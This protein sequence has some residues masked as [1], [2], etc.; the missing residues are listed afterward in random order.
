ML[1][2]SGV[3]S[4]CG[5]KG[6]YL[7]VSLSATVSSGKATSLNVALPTGGVLSGVA[8]G[9]RHQG[10]GGICVQSSSPEGNQVRTA[11][12]GA[13]SMTQLF[14]GSYDV[15]FVGGCGNQVSVAPQAYR[16]DP[17]FDA[18]R[19]VQ[20]TAGRTTAGIDATLQPGGVITGHVT[21]Q[22]G[23][24]L[25]RICVSVAGVTGGGGDGDFGDL[26]VTTNGFY[27]AKNL[28]P[29]QYSVSFIGALSRQIGCVAS[30]RYAEQDFRARNTGAT[31]DLVSVPGGVITSGI[32]AAL[33]PAGAISGVVRNRA[34]HRVANT[35]VTATDPRTQA[36]GFALAGGHGKYN[37][38]GIPAGRYRVEF[39]Q[40]ES[41]F[42][43]VSSNY[44][45]QWYRNRASAASATT[46]VVTA[47]HTT[48]RIDAALTRGGSITGQVVFGPDNRPVSFV[49]VFALTGNS[50][51]A[52][53]G[54]TDR[55]GRYLIS[56]LNTGVYQL[57][58]E[59][60]SPENTLA[61]QL[62]LTPVRVVA[63]RSVS[64]IDA[65]VSVG[66]SV[67]GVVSAQLAHSV[68]PAPGAC[69]LVLA[70][71]AG[72]LS[73]AALAGQGGSYLATNLA[74]GKYLIFTGYPGC[75]NDSP[76]LAPRFFAKL[77]QVTARQ[78]TTGVSTTLRPDGGIAGL[79]RGPG[80]T[81]VAGICAEAVP[82]SD[83][84]S[85]GLGTV[86]G[87]STAGGYTITDLAPGEYKVRFEVGCGARGYLTRWYKNARTRQQAAIVRV[88]ADQISTGISIT[89][90]RS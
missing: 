43:G 62:R 14:T 8:T 45:S 72:Y 19:P 52:S 27:R 87:V 1:F 26:E 30:G 34:G 81:P 17:T 59:P 66:G 22:A 28:P 89:L 68:R 7:P 41:G 3:F 56:G 55:D 46:V 54:L 38:S 82:L 74:A 35:C 23:R 75:S 76:A 71:R 65:R 37:I 25:S 11:S 47:A 84:L 53:M 6:N 50:G 10:L 24:P 48:P 20:V 5:N 60:C 51:G 88:R 21:D 36:T 16:G 2:R 78:T 4:N 73:T 9:A 29:G 67:S 40:C 85:S 15:G 70:T 18:P 57:E 83:G 39:A 44:A 80:H 31:P 86:I 49:C 79:V 64:G 61:G 69:V 77:V 58:F 33:A 13:Y 63:G 12:N 42:N 90:R 32:D